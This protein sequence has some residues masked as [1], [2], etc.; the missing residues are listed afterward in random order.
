MLFVAAVEQRENTAFHPLVVWVILAHIAYASVAYVL[1]ARPARSASPS[2]AHA[3]NYR[4]DAVVFVVLI[5]MIGGTDNGVSYFAILLF[6]FAAMTA[7]VGW[8]AGAGLK[9]TALT[10]TLFAAAMLVRA[11][12]SGV[13]PSHVFLHLTY[14][15]ALGVMAARW[16]GHHFTLHRRLALLRDAG[17]LSN[18]RFGADRTV[19]TLL[20]R[21]RQF[22]DANVCLLIVKSHDAGGWRV[23]HSDRDGASDP[24]Q[25]EPLSDELRDALPSLDHDTAA[26]Y[27]R[28]EPLQFWSPR[29]RIWADDPRKDERTLSERLVSCSSTIEELLGRFGGRSWL[30]VPVYTR[31]R[32]SGRLHLVTRQALNPA[33][34][35]FVALVIGNSMLVIENIR[36]LDELASSA[37][38]RER[39]R[40]ARDLHDSVI[41]PFIGVQLAL[42][43]VDRALKSGD[44]ATAADEVGRLL[45]LTNAAIDDLRTGVS[46][47]KTE[48]DLREGLA[49]ALRGFAAMF[50][51]ATGIAVDVSCEGAGRLGDRLGAELFQVVVEGLSNVRRHTSAARASIRL[52]VHTDSVTL[53]IEDQEGSRGTPAAFT[54]RSIRERTSALGGH[55]SV[56]RRRDG[57]TIVEVTIPL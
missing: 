45:S 48:P 6:L 14:I 56:D 52:A 20:E 11:G 57:R 37:A 43:A 15:V 40:L 2:A 17:T 38:R 8:G 24:V 23:R 36:L 7:S 5:A 13:E 12:T 44:S 49:P 25:E 26:I 46:G 28:P 29:A 18:P 42:V 32:S 27:V 19:G 50:A 41:Q 21:L 30:S 16:S 31:Q 51:E 53:Q 4:V 55:L 9:L 22:Y 34:A 35:R 54:P 33:D 3:L 39:H 1:V 47:L 10:A